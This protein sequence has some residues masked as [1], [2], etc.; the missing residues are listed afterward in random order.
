MILVSELMAELLSELERGDLTGTLTGTRCASRR[1]RCADALDAELVGVA[2]DSRAVAPGVLFACLRGAASDGHDHASQAVA[3]GAV[4]LLVDHELSAVGLGG[5]GRRRRHPQGPRPRL[6][7]R[8]RAPEPAAHHGRDHR[9]ER[10][11]DDGATHGGD[12]RSERLAD[13]GGRHVARRPNDAGGPRAAADA[14]DVRRRGRVGGGARSVVPRARPPPC[15]RHRVRRGDLHQPRT[16]PPRP[17]RIDRGVLPCQGA[18]V[19][20][21]IRTARAR[22][23]RRS[24]R[25]TA[26]RRDRRQRRTSGSS[27]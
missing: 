21:Q 13:R 20:P 22:Q 24:A 4:A 15:R 25:P 17:A 19:R 14:R 27:S 2:H 26:R 9:H 3:S 16:R 23:H 6:V 1:H 5:T 12:L 11:D 7:A 8:V 10:Q 18:T